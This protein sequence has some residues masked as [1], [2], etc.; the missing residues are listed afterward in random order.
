[1]EPRWDVVFLTSFC[2]REAG[3]RKKQLGPC[4]PPDL[5]GSERGEGEGGRVRD[6][7]GRWFTSYELP[8]DCYR[9]IGLASP[10]RLFSI[11]SLCR[12][13]FRVIV[14]RNRV[15]GEPSHFAP[16]NV[17]LLHTRRGRWREKEREREG[18]KESV[19]ANDCGRIYSGSGS[20][21]MLISPSEGI[22]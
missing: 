16:I 12:S 10:V 5:I 3:C 13:N 11:S 21:R 7:I 6:A 14:S 22:H 15:T 1:M 9:L 8:Q 4:I 2:D 17:F 18:G 19:G 20:R